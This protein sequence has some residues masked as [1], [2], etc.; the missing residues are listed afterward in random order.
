M[1]SKPIPLGSLSSDLKTVAALCKQRMRSKGRSNPEWLL[2]VDDHRLVYFSVLDGAHAQ[3]VARLRTEW[4][5]GVYRG[6]T[7]AAM[8]LD[9]L[10]D[11]A[12]RRPKTLASIA[13]HFCGEVA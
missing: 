2:W 11:E 13:E 10:R 5:V 1:S 4:V 3:A 7:T 8:L 12:A 9:D 6:A